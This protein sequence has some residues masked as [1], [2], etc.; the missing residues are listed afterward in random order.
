M[1]TFRLKFLWT[2]VWASQLVIFYLCFWLMS[3]V[4][5]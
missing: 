4:H 5:S 3:A 2:S 1:T